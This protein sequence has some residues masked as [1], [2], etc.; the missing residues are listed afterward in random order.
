MAV[1]ERITFQA[2]LTQMATVLGAW[3][4]HLDEV[5]RKEV[6]NEWKGVRKRCDRERSYHN[7]LMHSRLSIEDLRVL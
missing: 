6:L 1:V 4:Q 5:E 3:T 2:L 7:K